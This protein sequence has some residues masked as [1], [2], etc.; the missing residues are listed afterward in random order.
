MGRRSAQ[1]NG[2]KPNQKG[3]VSP[4]D[5]LYVM[6]LVRGVVQTLL[7]NPRTTPRNRPPGDSP[8]GGIQCIHYCSLSC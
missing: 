1:H 5:R 6:L 2:Q 8:R 3:H 4:R 7:P